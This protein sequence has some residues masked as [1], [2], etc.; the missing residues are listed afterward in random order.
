M[1]RAP[2]A[3]EVRL[4]AKEFAALRRWAGG[5]AAEPRLA[6]RARIIL[7]CPDGV[8]SARVAAD[9]KMPAHTVHKWRSRFATRWLPDLPDMSRP[10]IRKRASAEPSKCSRTRAWMVRRS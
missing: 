9:L 7:A 4:S 10:D 2:G 6:E 8:P 5:A 1:S 3:A